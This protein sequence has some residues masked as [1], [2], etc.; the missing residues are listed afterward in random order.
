MVEPVV[1]RRIAV[2]GSSGSGKT[3]MARRLAEALAL[4]HVEL[5]ALHHKPG[6]TPTPPDEFRSELT[7]ALDLADRTTDGWTMCGGYSVVDDIRSARADT[8]VWVDLPRWLVTWQ[9]VTRT[10][11]RAITRE[12]LW[13]GN[14]EPLTNL[15]SWDPEKNIIRWSWV[16]FD[17][18]RERFARHCATDWSSKHVHRLRSRSEVRAFIAALV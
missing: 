7:E 1:G 11:R 18:R 12:E 8:I 6:W 15:T 10:I 13:N 9:V 5:D 3:T 4:T 14:R 2:V 17:E 16:H